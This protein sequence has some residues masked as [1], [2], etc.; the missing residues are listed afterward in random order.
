MTV[1][2]AIN[3]LG[4]IGRL[5]LRAALGR[6]DVTLA[7][8]ND[9]NDL[10]ALV[11][12]IRR[13][14]VHGPFPGEVQCA[15][16]QL[17]LNG[18][19][20]PMLRG[21]PFPDWREYGVDVVLECSGGGPDGHKARE[22]IR[23]G[24]ER[25][26]I[27]APAPH[28]DTTLVLGANAGTF[29]ASCHQIISMASCTT[30]C[31]APVLTALQPFGLGRVHLDSV[32]AYTNSQRI[33]DAPHGD[34]RMAR[35]AGLNIIPSDSSTG[36]SIYE[37]M[38]QLRGKFTACA[39]RVP[40]PCGSL[41]SIVAEVE[42]PP[43]LDELRRLFRENQNNIIA[44]SEEPLVSSDIID[45]THSAIIDGL[46]LIVNGQWLHVLAWYDN[47]VGYA[48]RLVDL[49]IYIAGAK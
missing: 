23:L 14:S 15:A 44:Y 1:R 16:G 40:V 37:V 19:R 26:I 11:P 20:V 48:H 2:I 36:G 31:L 46:R 28:V 22:H 32:N 42:R 33:V 8:V 9:R 38:P 30:N 39:F 13:D 49:A 17:I 35:A 27:S 18:E 47:E 4:R 12:L 43:A 29:E 6:E 5:A 25:V 7:A 24:A 34:P 45:D 21:R 3:G 41:C 10:T